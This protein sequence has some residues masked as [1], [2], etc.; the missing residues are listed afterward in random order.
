MASLA[1][2]IDSVSA[3]ASTGVGDLTG[4]VDSPSIMRSVGFVG[5]MAVGDGVGVYIT[6][7]VVDSASGDTGLFSYLGGCAGGETTRTTSPSGSGS[8]PL[9]RREDKPRTPDRFILCLVL[10]ERLYALKPYILTVDLA[11]RL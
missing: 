2:A 5:L 11:S 4:V 7:N 10:P 3:A 8:S 6:D 9:E 1:V